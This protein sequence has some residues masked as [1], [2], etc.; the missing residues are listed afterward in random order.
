MYLAVLLTL[1]TACAFTSVLAQTKEPQ[2]RW[3][4]LCDDTLV[5][6][7]DTYEKGEK[8]KEAINWFYNCVYRIHCERWSEGFYNRQIMLGNI[9]AQK[10]FYDPTQEWWKNKAPK[11]GLSLA[12]MPVV[13]V[14]YKVTYGIL[15]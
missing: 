10:E 9:R 12:W 4:Q 1:T 11:R 2:G 6:C 7:R 15:Q 3:N 13:M 5:L 8:N 14:M